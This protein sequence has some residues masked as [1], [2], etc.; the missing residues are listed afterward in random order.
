MMS[1]P[2]SLRFLK[3]ASATPP[4]AV[5]RREQTAFDAITAPGVAL[6]VWER[7]LPAQISAWL[8]ALDLDDIEDLD[9]DC[10]VT[11]AD[12][13]IAAA[14]MEA[15]YPQAPHTEWLCD[16]VT[17]LI[18]RYAT[19]LSLARVAI[20]L[21]VIETDACRKFHADHMTV[22]AISTYLGPAT[23]W[24]M[25]DDAAAVAAGRHPDTVAIKQLA[26]GDVALIKGRLW[27][28]DHPLVHRSPPIAATGERRLVLVLDPVTEDDAR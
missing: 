10:D 17:A 12:A 22:R 21:E 8:G 15:G 23:Q 19:L 5:I 27:A 26:A 11:C 28:A 7:R 3:A 13:A 16:D 18:R 4:H 24:L 1:R 2:L 20:R 6:A 14:L 25:P 9:F